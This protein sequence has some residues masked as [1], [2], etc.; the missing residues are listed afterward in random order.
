MPNT[1][2]DALVI[3]SGPAGLM[4]AE[5]LAN[6][7]RTVTIIEGK[8]SAGRKLL[9]AGK[10]GL[11]LTKDEPLETFIRAYGSAA[12]WLY[13]MI[14][15]LDPVE[16]MAFAEDL[17]QPVFTGTTGRVFPKAMKASPLL[18]AWLQRL[19]ATMHLRWRWTGFDGD[20]LTFDTPDGPQTL[21][22]NVTVLALGGASWSRLGSDGAWADILADKG[23]EL[24]PFKP[25]N[26]G[27]TVAWSEHMAP[28][29][30]TP[31]KN[32]ALIAGGTRHRGEAVISHRGLEGGGIYA[33]SAA[34]RDGGDLAFDLL[35][36]RPVEGLVSRL[37]KRPRKQTLTKALTGLGLDPLKRALLQ[38]F[39]RPLPE[40][41]AA[42]AALIKAL[43]VK[44]QGPR[45]IDEAI[46]TAGGVPQ[47]SVTQGLMLEAIPG[48]FVAG[49]MLDWE[50]PTGGYLINAC[51]A[52][53]RWAGRYAGMYHP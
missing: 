46:S 18:R 8:P 28:H 38:E 2:I 29:F 27:F 15:Q 35:P 17:G 19:D 23:V 3:G 45:P 48:M 33:V 7:G 31:L 52:T 11:N 50:A 4:A 39:A 41:P 30:G 13:P 10:S 32:I 25:S 49:E 36:D 51:L 37:R 1:S 42:L 21:A 5:S 26:M 43:P 53:G 34:V 6:A 14:A 20:A 9:M 24:A 16:V 40:D 22:P 12:D 44:H 47:S